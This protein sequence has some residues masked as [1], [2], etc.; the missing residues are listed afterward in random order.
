MYQ[1]HRKFHSIQGAGPLLGV[2]LLVLGQLAWADRVKDLADIA[3]VRANQLVGY[4]LVVGLDGSGDKDTDSPM[5]I[6]SLTAMLTRLGVQIPAGT[7]IKP[8]N[9]AAVMLTADL[10]AFAKRGQVIDVTVSSLGNS[11]SLRGGTLLMAPLKGADGQVYAM[12]QGNLL[13]S[14]LSADGKDGSKVSV[15]VP[16]VGRIPRGA[17]VEREVESPFAATTPLVLNLRESDFATAKR[18]ADA[19]NQTVGE[20][21]ARALDGVSVE[22]SAPQDPTQRVAFVSMLEDLKVDSSLPRARVIVN[23]RTGTVVINSEVRVRPSAVSH[24][25]LTVT[26]SEDVRVSQPEPMSMGQTAVVPKSNVNVKE[27]KKP[28]FKFAPGPTLE[29]VVRAVNEVGASPSDLVAILE[30][31][32]EAGSLKAELIVI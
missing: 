14:G 15:N 17:T 1:S 22:V 5:M 9:V 18:I 12:A 19:V 20:G 29:E 23:S 6:Q 21:S 27:E 25:S 13:V 2:L 32:K 4:G 16:N 26:I 28:M 3:G 24:G 11:K 31:L 30:A 8:K 10:P 7:K